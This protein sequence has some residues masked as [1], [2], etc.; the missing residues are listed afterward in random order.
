MP[1]GRPYGS[2][3]SGKLQSQGE[4][5]YTAQEIAEMYGVDD[6]TVRRW[7][8]RGALPAVVLPHKGKRTAYRF[9]VGQIRTF[10]PKFGE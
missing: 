10:D 7:V 5:L 2:M 9:T 8:K 4:K 1:G 3:S 6:T